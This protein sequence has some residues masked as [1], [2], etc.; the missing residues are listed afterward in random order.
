MKFLANGLTLLEKLAS[1][2]GMACVVLMMIHVTA[3]VAGRSFFGHPVPG[4]ITVVSSFYMVALSFI[5][6][7]VAERLNAHI[8]VDIIFE[9][10]PAW[11]KRA[12]VS[13]NYLFVTTVLAFATVRTWQVAVDKTNIGAAIQQGTA[14]VPVWQSY[15]LLPVGLGLMAL[16]CVTKLGL[17][18][19]NPDALLDEQGPKTENIY[20]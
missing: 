14:M 3:D 1:F 7:A 9:R 11:M 10:L 8:S 5:P 20:E 16:L 2:A 15:W 6:L 4:T 18:L 19:V 17:S 12:L 13:L